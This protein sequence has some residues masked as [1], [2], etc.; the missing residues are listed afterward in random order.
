MSYFI[1]ITPSDINQSFIKRYL[2]GLRRNEDGEL[3]FISIDQLGTDDDEIVIN[4]IGTGDENYPFFE[5]GIDFLEGITIDHEIEYPNLRYPQLKWD[6]RF[7][8]Y[9]VDVNGRLSIKINRNHVYE[10][11]IS[12]EGY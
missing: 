9:Y 11:G 8:S 10:E 6:N 3:F 12:T 1:G 7:L 4:E 5:E 2:Y